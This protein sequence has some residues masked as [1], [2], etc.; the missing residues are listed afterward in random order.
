MNNW[1]R[2]LTDSYITDFLTKYCLKVKIKLHLSII[3]DKI[4]LI[5]CYKRKDLIF[6]LLEIIN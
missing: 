6:K 3:T 4:A 2:T 1:I 5:Y